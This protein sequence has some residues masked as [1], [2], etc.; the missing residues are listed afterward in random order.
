MSTFS[1]GHRFSHLPTRADTW[2]AEVEPAVERYWRN[3]RDGGTEND[4]LLAALDLFSTTQ[5][6]LLRQQLK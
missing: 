3:R 5:E 1:L 4:A 6:Q 2:N